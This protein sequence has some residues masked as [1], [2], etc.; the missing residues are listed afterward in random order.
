M[1]PDEIVQTIDSISGVYANFITTPLAQLVAGQVPP[2]YRL[3]TMQKMAQRGINTLGALKP[4]VKD[5]DEL[6]LDMGN[7]TILISD[8]GQALHFSFILDPEI[9]DSVSRAVHRFHGKALVHPL[10]PPESPDPSAVEDDKRYIREV[11][12][13]EGGTA[14]VYR[15]TDA[16]LKRPVALKRF[17]DSGDMGIKGDYLSELQSVS[18]VRHPNVVSTYDAGVDNY[19]SFIVMELIE[20]Q[21][22]EAMLQQDS[23]D[24]DQ[25]MDLAI[26]SLEGLSATHR[27]GL[28]HLDIKASNIMVAEQLSGRLH[29]KLIDY[30]RA[31]LIS[32]PSTGDPPMGAGLLGSIYSMSP[33]F[34]R[35]EALDDRSDVYSLGTVF[36]AALSGRKAF[37]G[38]STL[39]IMAA[40]LNGYAKPLKEVAE[41]IP[42]ELCA[43]VMGLIEHDQEKRPISAK[44][45]LEQLL[46]INDK[47]SLSRKVQVVGR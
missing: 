46:I 28:L 10:I 1:D 25:F 39:E 11:Q 2:D 35:E 47:G 3:S 42:E 29:V 15:A 43:W 30:G 45:A 6:R 31:R 24:M 7:F 9:V 5:C 17:K 14:I 12:I 8:L 37:E 41:H 4:I 32:N 40:H 33:E 27:A 23:L 38:G 34:L 20:G 22:L 44:A 26:Q 13:G 36:Y 19:G 16:L 21:D 18:R